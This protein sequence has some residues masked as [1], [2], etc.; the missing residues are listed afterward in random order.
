MI[1]MD[2]QIYPELQFRGL[3]MDLLSIYQ[4]QYQCKL[5]RRI[6]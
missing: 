6:C 1:I 3:E 4:K 2:G 5:R